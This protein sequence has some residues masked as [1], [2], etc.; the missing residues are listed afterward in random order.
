VLYEVYCRAG[1][2]LYLICTCGFY[3]EVVFPSLNHVGLKLFY[4]VSL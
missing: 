3:R 4:E 1:G 2:Y